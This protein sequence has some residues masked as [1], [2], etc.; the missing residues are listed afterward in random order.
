MTELISR[1]QKMSQEEFDE[2]NIQDITE[3]ALIAYVEE[4]ERR[5]SPEWKAEQERKEKESRG[6][7]LPAAP[8][9]GIQVQKG[10]N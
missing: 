8:S 3:T 10:A 6:S 7:V 5:N 1:Y 9:L 2:I 4:P